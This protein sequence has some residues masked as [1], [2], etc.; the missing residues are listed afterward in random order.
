MKKT[1]II[2]AFLSII[3]LMTACK[4]RTI[5]HTRRVW[6]SNRTLRW[7]DAWLNRRPWWE[8]CRL[9]CVCVRI[10]LA[11]G[12]RRCVFGTYPFGCYAQTACGQ[13]HVEVQRLFRNQSRS[14]Y[15]LDSIIGWW[16]VGG[17][18]RMGCLWRHQSHYDQFERK[19]G[20]TT[21]PRTCCILITLNEW[22]TE[23]APKQRGF[24]VFIFKRFKDSIIQHI[25]LF[26][27]PNFWKLCLKV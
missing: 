27:H 19:V 18:K 5:N 20:K 9:R 15:L 3:T 14:R 12:L 26:L 8:A 11:F 17:W 22:K 16:E 23:A 1:V 25:F 6:H 21:C 4:K 10:H 13:D 2:L 7:L 24:V